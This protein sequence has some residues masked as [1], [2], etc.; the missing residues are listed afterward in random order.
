MLIP[1]FGLYKCQPY[2][3]EQLI[4]KSLADTKNRPFS[5]TIFLEDNRARTKH[6]Y[7]SFDKLDRF[8]IKSD[9]SKINFYMNKNESGHLISIVVGCFTTNYQRALE[10]VYP[11]TQMILSQWCMKYQRPIGVYDTH[12]KDLDNKAIWRIPHS[13]PN[14]LPMIEFP[15]VTMANSTLASLISVFREGMNSQSNG[16]RFL[17][18][19]KILEAY[20]SLGPFRETNLYCKEKG[21]KHKRSTLVVT[22]ELLLGSYKAEYHELYLGKKFTWCKNELLE[23]RN[24]IAHPFLKNEKYIEL[25]TFAIQAGLSAYANLLERVALKILNEEFM[26][27][28]K[29]STDPIDTSVIKSYVGSNTT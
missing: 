24:A 17:N 7:I 2:C 27:W 8:H 6:V 23:F 16:N 14:T 19:F 29:L 15:I 26:L 11:Y 1:N 21:I 20:P 25:D 10:I 3:N 13:A 28:D 12:I 5:V 18:Y 9:E 4:T 22:E